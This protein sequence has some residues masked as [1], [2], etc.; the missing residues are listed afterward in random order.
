MNATV[1]RICAATGPH[2]RFRAREMQLGLREEF[3]YFRCTSCGC[4][5]I[6][7]V[8]ADLGRFYPST[9]YSFTAPAAAS[10]DRSLGSRLRHARDRAAVL[11]GGAWGRA[12]LAIFPEGALQPVGALRP[13]RDARILDVGSG[14]GTHLRALQRLGFTR[15]LGIDPFLDR[16]R[17]DPSGPR[18]LKRSVHEVEGTAA[19]DLI[20]YHH[21]FEHVP[22]PVDQ[23]RSVARLLAPG[24]TCLLRIPVS[25]GDAWERY[26]TDWVQLDAPRHLHLHTRAS[27]TEAARR[28]GLVVAGVTHDSTAF[29][30]WGSE[31]YRRDV[32]LAALGADPRRGATRRFG[33]LRMA[34][35]A[36]WARDLNRH[37]RGDQAAFLLRA[38]PTPKG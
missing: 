3:D 30:F 24:G 7:T 20:M 17:T 16:D 6:E 2:A 8:P 10:V 32:P 21:V 25:D 33:R 34:R 35:F 9:Y 13:T 14:A 19:W 28:A 36:R 1:C 23:L 31:L 4:L 15:L 38:A 26:G 12:L 22:D 5:Q 18:L 29:Q 27:L 11:G 37:G